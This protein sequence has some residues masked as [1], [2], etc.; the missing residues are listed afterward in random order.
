MA[1]LLPAPFPGPLAVLTDPA[2]GP[3]L[4][5]LG[6]TLRQPAVRRTLPLLGGLA[7]LGAVAL[8]WAMLAPAPQRVLYSELADAEKARVVGALDKAAISYR[9]DDASGAL[10]V[11]A[12]DLYRARML[13]ASDGALATP[14]SGTD[15]LDKLPLGASRAVEG[16]RLR[17]AREHELILSLMEIDGVEAARV[18]LG[19]PQRSVFVRD[20]VAPT[21]SVMLRLARGRQLADSQVTAVVNLVAGSVPGLSVDAVRILDQHGRLLSAAKSSDGDRLELQA[22]MEQKLRGQLDQL[23]LPMLGEGNFSSEIQV[24]LDMD[25]VT[26]ARE[27]YEKQGVVRSE[28][29]SQS[30]SQGAGQ[31]IGIPG[32]LSNTPPP[33][34]TASPGPPQGTAP[35]ANAAAPNNGESSTART[36]EL[37]REVSVANSGPGRI[38]RI[39]VAVALSEAAMKKGKAADVEQI[40]QLVSAAVGIDP[41]RGDQVAVVARTFQPP[42]D[43]ALPFYEAGWFGPLVRGV[44]ALIGVLLVLLFAVRPLLKLLKREPGETEMGAAEGAP[45]ALAGRA[46][47]PSTTLPATD[48]TIIA[49]QI[50]LA[51]RMVEEK[52][53]Q[54]VVALRRM[55]AQQGAAS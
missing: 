32:V 4:T 41:Q 48:G 30:S 54:A 40:K 3:M 13:V 38:K 45:L 27:S 1:Y 7:A 10:T 26:K 19:E 15:M 11:D 5:R 21:A 55:L 22:R 25:D 43:D 6:A 50:E 47:P 39:S 35:A 2:G 12:D 52:P 9:L 49:K 53:E 34:A 23:L 18:H 46:S 51:Q 14:D 44:V 31:A 8:T 29:Q 42:V 33:T 28:T 37:G 36:Y 17:S 24:E 16:D 20:E